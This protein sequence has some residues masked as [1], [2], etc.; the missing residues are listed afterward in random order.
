MATCRECKNEVEKLHSIKINGRKQ[1]LC[2]DCIEILEEEGL[3]AQES[4][5]VIREMMGFKGR[6]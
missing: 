5:S 1:R 4:E 2:E 6:R 3:I